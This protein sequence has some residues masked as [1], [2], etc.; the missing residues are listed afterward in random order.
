MN[1]PGMGKQGLR[2]RGITQVRIHI[3]ADRSLQTTRLL[4]NEV[5]RQVGTMSHVWSQN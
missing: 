1:V 5:K 2:Q 3:C 4:S